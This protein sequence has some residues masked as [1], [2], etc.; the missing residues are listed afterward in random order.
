LPPELMSLIFLFCLPDD[1]FIFPDPSSAPLLLCRICR[2]WR[3]I[4]LAMPGL[5]ASLFLHMGR[6]FPMFPNFKEPA[7]AD[8]AAFFCQWISN[9]RSLP[10]SFR[11]DD[12]PKYDDWEPGPTKAEYR[13]VIGH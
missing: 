6:F 1:E 7:L 13:S 5:W 11:V 8:L 10:L 2:Q 12:Y 4:A 3:H 9:A